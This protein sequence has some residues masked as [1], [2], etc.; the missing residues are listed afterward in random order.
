MR[1]QP[2]GNAGA[3]FFGDYVTWSARLQAMTLMLHDCSQS[4][5]DEAMLD[6]FEEVS[7]R[8]QGNRREM[9]SMTYDDIRLLMIGE[10]KVALK[11]LEVE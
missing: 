2:V 8:V 11:I 7:R 6:R 4:E 1:L 5:P 3:A 10:M 9:I